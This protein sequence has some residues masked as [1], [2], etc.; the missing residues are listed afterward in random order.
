MPNNTQLY[1]QTG[2]LISES[3]PNSFQFMYFLKPW[4]AGTRDTPSDT[5][6]W[7]A[8]YPAKWL[9]RIGETHSDWLGVQTGNKTRNY[10]LN[11]N[12]TWRCSLRLP[13]ESCSWTLKYCK[14]SFCHVFPPTESCSG[15][16]TWLSDSTSLPSIWKHVRCYYIYTLKSHCRQNLLLFYI[17]AHRHLPSHIWSHISL[18]FRCKANTLSCILNSL[19]STKCNTLKEL[20]QF[21]KLWLCFWGV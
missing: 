4:L 20:L 12:W 9:W 2:N 19:C 14:Q 7:V 16:L 17:Y 13:Y 10:L 8:K 1:I 18:L 15:M 6:P 21:F 5:L 3:I 11:W